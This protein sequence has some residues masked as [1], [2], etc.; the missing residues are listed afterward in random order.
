VSEY[1]YLHE[2][3]D[4]LFVPGGVRPCAELWRLLPALGFV[5][6]E[7]VFAVDREGKVPLWQARAIVSVYVLLGDQ[8][9]YDEEGQWDSVKLR[10]LLATLPSEH[11]PLFVDKAVALAEALG[12]QM[13]Y[14]N[15]VVSGEQLRADLEAGARELRDTLGEPGSKEVAATIKMTYPRRSLS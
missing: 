13:L 14:R 4:V 12:T 3:E 7:D 2:A 8:D 10:Y 6:D 5:L 11:I 9:I 15:Q 1:D